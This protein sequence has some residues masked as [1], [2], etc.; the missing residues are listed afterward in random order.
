MEIFIMTGELL[1]LEKEKSRFIQSQGYS[2][3]EEIKKDPIFT[4][5]GG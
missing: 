1:Y 5:A 2:T 4:P 3:K